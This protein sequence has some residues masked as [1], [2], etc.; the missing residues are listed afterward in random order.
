MPVGC[1]G[2]IMLTVNI[3][4]LHRSDTMAL[5]RRSWWYS[6]IS[7]A[8]LVFAQSVVGFVGIQQPAQNQRSSATL[9]SNGNG[10]EVDDRNRRILWTQKPVQVASGILGV[11][12]LELTVCPA[13]AS[14]SKA[15]LTYEV[16]KSE[17]EWKEQLSPIQFQILRKGGTERAGYSILESEKR[18]G[19]YKCAGCGTDLFDSKDKFNSGTGWPSFAR[20]LAGV[21]IEQVN[22]LMASFSGVELKCR[23]CGG[24]LGDVFQ[25][26]FLFVGTEAAKTGQRFCIDG[27]ALTFYPE[28]QNEKPLRG[29]TPKQQSDLPSWLEPP[30]IEPRT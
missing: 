22:P 29:D 5:C 14:S 21:E 10:K 13:W 4:L 7:L 17:A 30:K 27:V 6:I 20:N 15:Q 26:G 2:F 25:D 19:I 11:A 28:D 9:C 1:E 3:L 23:T 18:P 8:F 24:H 16:Q 12:G